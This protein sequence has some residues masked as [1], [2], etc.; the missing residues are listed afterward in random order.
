MSNILEVFGCLHF[1]PKLHFE[2]IPDDPGCQQ[3]KFMLPVHCP[4]PED[5]KKVSL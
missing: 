2:D 4:G 5:S 3:Q 1:P